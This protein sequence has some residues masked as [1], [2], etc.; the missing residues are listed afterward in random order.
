M[1][2]IAEE[3]IKTLA[4]ANYVVVLTGAGVSAESGISTFRDPDGLWSKFNP[5]ELA[6]VDGFMSNPELVWSWYQFRRDTVNNAKPNLGH[7][8][9]AQMEDL[10]PK[11]L[12]ITQ[13]VDRLHQNAGSKKVVE[14]HGNIIDNH[15]LRCQLPFYG[16]TF[17][18]DGKVP[19]CSECGGFIRPSVVWFGEMLPERAI[20]SAEKA[21]EQCDVI[22]SIGTSSEVYPAANIPII[23]KRA[24]AIVVEVNPNTTMLSNYAD[25]RLPFNSAQI[26]PL[27]VESLNH[28]RKEYNL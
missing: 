24:G 19:I 6:S 21:A 20:Y 16:E 3:L 18:P 11:F 2:E 12:L 14:L 22:F 25:F 1:I 28:Y 5:S 7:F 15:C 9:I 13:N 26:M 4:R 23:A 8:A 10:F 17:L 27:L